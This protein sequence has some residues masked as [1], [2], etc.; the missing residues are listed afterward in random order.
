VAP[1]VRGGNPRKWNLEFSK[2]IEILR[3]S[4]KLHIEKWEN[5][6]IC[7]LQFFCEHSN[8]SQTCFLF[9]S[10]IFR[11]T[12]F[13]LIF[14]QSEYFRAIKK[15]FSSKKVTAHWKLATILNFRCHFES[16]KQLFFYDL[17][18]LLSITDSK[19]ENI[20][21]VNID[22]VIVKNQFVATILRPA[23]ILK[24]IKIQLF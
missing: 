4:S 16:E 22:L 24:Q 6:C 12:V 5:I 11:S 18:G 20:K 9:F 15:I 17:C 10:K 7:M 14:K 3:F 13:F 21:I 19:R 8:Y 2:P 1:W 23:A